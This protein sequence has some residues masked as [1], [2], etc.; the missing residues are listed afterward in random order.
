MKNWKG[1]FE[2]HILGRGKD[3]YNIGAVYKVTEVEDGYE[4]RVVG[5]EVYTVEI[6]LE[7]S[8][9]DEMWCSCPYADGG[10][11]CKHMAAVL[12][13]LEKSAFE[14]S[15]KSSALP[16]SDKL[17][18]VIDEMTENEIR[19]FLLTLATSDS[20]IRNKIITTFSKSIGA[21]EI[22]GLKNEVDNIADEHSGYHGFIEYRQADSYVNELDNFMGNHVQALIDRAHYLLTFELTNYVFV[23]ISEQ[24]MDD[25]NGG[26]G[27]IAQSCCEYWKEILERCSKQDEAVIFEWFLEHQ[28]GYVVDYMEDYLD[29]FLMDNFNDKDSIVRKLKLLDEQIGA[30]LPD[31]SWSA[32]Y[33][34]KNNI[35]KRLELMKRLGCSE[36]EI[37]D[38][39]QRFRQ[40]SD[41]RKLEIDDYLGK[42]E[43]NKAIEVLIESKE[44]DKD[45]AG[46][47]SGYSKM[48]IDIYE[49]QNMQV[50]YKNEL[51]YN[52]FS[53]GS[54]ELGYI[55]KLKACCTGNE[56][57]EYREKLL[58]DRN[59]WNIKYALL[60]D[61][62]LYQRLFD[63]IK[64]SGQ[65]STLEQYEETLK[66]EF[67]EEIKQ[68]YINYV[69][70]QAKN[71]ADR[72]A[73]SSLAWYLRKICEYPNGEEEAI[74]I[75]ESWKQAYRKRPAMMDELKKAGF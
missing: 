38:F 58:S 9:I 67:P 2:T 53:L 5:S 55:K 39:K 6:D 11:Y 27:M 23:S 36:V 35:L 69:T 40:L 20:G 26:T 72:K 25:S 65:I 29:N 59:S 10:R 31:Q 19:G 15:G 33:R 61:E 51:L 13:Y 7:D 41:I 50:E 62:K 30:S 28:R 60:E 16:E 46:L 1:L 48:L 66:D 64:R 18:K 24:D 12:Y 68:L 47:V 42:S 75:A 34:F 3:Y 54:D 22:A 52:V 57:G 8:V 71:V 70:N 74:D 49:S 44:L 63:E 73:Y 14:V 56:W 45:W 21:T 32:S 17:K 37:S 43:Y 4:A